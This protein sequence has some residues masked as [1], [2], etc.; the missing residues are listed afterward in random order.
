[1]LRAVEVL[2]VDDEVVDEPQKARKHVLLDQQAGFD[3]GVHAP[4]AHAAQ[5]FEG[6]RP[7]GHHLAAGERDAATLGVEHSVLQERFFRLVS[8]YLAA[9]KQQRPRGAGVQAALAECAGRPVDV[10]ALVQSKRPLL[11]GGHAVAAAQAVRLLVPQA[12]FQMQPFRVLTPGTTQGAALEKQRR[13]QAGAVVHGEALDL[14]DK[15]VH[16]AS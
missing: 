7:L 10:H 11:T 3:G 6:K 14:K 13:A 1:M 9:V 4:R 12:R 8:A 2:D 16:T 5:K 15:A